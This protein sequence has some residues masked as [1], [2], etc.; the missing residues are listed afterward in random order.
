M[1]LKLL[2]FC[3]VEI[4]PQNLDDI[5]VVNLQHDTAGTCTEYGVVDINHLLAIEPS[6]YIVALNT[7]TQGV[8]LAGLEDILLLVGNLNQPTTAIR[9]INCACVIT[10]RSN[11]ALPAINNIALE[12]AMNE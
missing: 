1:Q 11:L 12:T 5:V 2:E 6:F 7:Q 9:L 8:P 10:L 4:T 3:E